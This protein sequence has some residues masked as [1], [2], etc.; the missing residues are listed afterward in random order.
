[1]GDALKSLGLIC[2]EHS[3]TIVNTRGLTSCCESGS[4]IGGRPHDGLPEGQI[5]SWLGCLVPAEMTEHLR[6]IA[7]ATAPSDGALV[8]GEE[9]FDQGSD[10]V[11]DGSAV[12]PAEAR[13]QLMWPPF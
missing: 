2:E 8:R 5:G 12:Q 11:D 1:M 10:D 13:R 6:D 7:S 9:W 3:W 4:G